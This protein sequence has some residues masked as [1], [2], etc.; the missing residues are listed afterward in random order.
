MFVTVNILIEM[1]HVES[2][3]IFL[4]H[5]QANVHMNDSNC[6]FVV[7]TKVIDALLF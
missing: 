4:I 5:V 2:I 6:S 1:Y 7:I 3:S